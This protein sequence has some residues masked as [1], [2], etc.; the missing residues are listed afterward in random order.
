MA[1]R[2]PRT[3]TAS[4]T[5]DS[6]YSDCVTVIDAAAGLTVTLPAAT[7]TG[8]EYDFFIGTTVTSN[9]VI[10]QVASASDTMAGVAAFAADGGNTA[11]FFETAATS[12]TITMD[13][14]TQGGILGN[15]IKLRDVKAGVWAVSITGSATGSEATPFSAAVS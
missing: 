15:R 1:T 11:V 13:G 14:S 9:D 4:A 10:I 8:Y 6:S 12:D 7:G 3:L 2:E 5:V